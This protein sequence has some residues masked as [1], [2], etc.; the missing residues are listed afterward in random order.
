MRLDNFC[1]EL[2]KRLQKHVFRKKSKKKKD[3]NMYFSSDLSQM[4]GKLLTLKK[5]G[6]NF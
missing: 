3:E 4:E 1:L 6:V 2:P 5:K